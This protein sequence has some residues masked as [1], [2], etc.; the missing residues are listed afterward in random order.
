MILLDIRR[1]WPY[2]V[3]MRK[4]A[5]IIVIALVVWKLVIPAMGHHSHKAHKGARKAHK[6]SALV[7]KASDPT[8][9]VGDVVAE[10]AGQATANVGKS[11]QGTIDKMGEDMIQ[12][13]TANLDNELHKA[14][15]G[16]IDS[17]SSDVNAQIASKMP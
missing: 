6:G 16:I 14:T 9:V 8:Q 4:L 2:I 10:I 1:G 15:N 12:N 5:L 11:V 3:D 7:V 17:I 13:G